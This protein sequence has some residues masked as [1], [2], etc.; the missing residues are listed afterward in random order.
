MKNFLCIS[1]LLISPFWAAMNG[2]QSLLPVPR[3]VHG[4]PQ[5]PRDSAFGGVPGVDV[6][7]HHHVFVFHRGAQPVRCFDGDSGRQIAVWQENEFLLPH[8][9]EVDAQDNV[10]LTDIDRHQVFQFSHDGRLKREWGVRQKPGEDERHFNKPTD[11]AVLPDGT[12]FVADGYGNSRVVKF[13]SS[14]AYVRA[15]G[16][17]GQE[18]GQFVTPHS[19]AVDDQRR[20]YVADR[21]NVR[22]QV[23]DENGKFLAQWKSEALG[24]PWGLDFDPV[25]HL[26]AVDGGDLPKGPNN[27]ARV[28]RLDLTGKI[29]VK[30]GSAG[31]Y[32]GQFDWAHGVA[33]GPDGV[34][35]VSDVRRG[36]RVQKF[37]PR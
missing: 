13:D 28:L 33:A 11:V 25:G 31:A 21:G 10:W 32:D 2:G 8:G 36:R 7:S 27:R 29:L 12:F 22:I 37:D 14:G 15:W 1:I 34:V 26:L 23:F 16:T 19:I 30:W 9:L 4:W 6:D 24:R 17:R 20:V 5:L 18:P 3:V 35:Y